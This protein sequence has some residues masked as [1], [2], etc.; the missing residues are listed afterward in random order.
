MATELVA[1]TAQ[2]NFEKSLKAPALDPVVLAVANEYLSGK[3][4]PEIAEEYGVNTDFISTLVEKKEVK[5]YIDNV[6]LTQGYL[7]RIRRLDLINKVID[8]KLLEATETGVYSKKDLL[9]WL[10]LLQSM[11]EGA[12]PKEKGPAVAIQVNNYDKLMGEILGS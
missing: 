7:N 11:E 4:I 10:K 1:D 6:Y 8:S 9:E 3:T 2:N 5:A 12:R